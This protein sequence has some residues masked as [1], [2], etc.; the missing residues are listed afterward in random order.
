MLFKKKPAKTSV[1]PAKGQAASSPTGPSAGGDFFES[2]KR[3]TSAAQDAGV[4]AAQPRVLIRVD[5]ISDV[6]GMKG[7]PLPGRQDGGCIVPNVASGGVSNQSVPAKEGD[8]FVVEVRVT[9]RQPPSGGGSSPYFVGPIFFGAK[10]D[11]VQ[12]WPTQR[13]LPS[14]FGETIRVE[15]TALA[16]TAY[17]RIGMCGTWAKDNPADYLVGFS[18]A[19]L[20]QIG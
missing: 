6:R 4:V 12:W 18:E 9:L 2:S 15:A 17:V 3:A 16:N 11:V 20:Y 13:E 8:V 14:S 19:R 10:D 1:G 5:D 7:D